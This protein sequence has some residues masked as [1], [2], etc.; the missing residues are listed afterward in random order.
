MRRKRQ[1]SRRKT[2]RQVG[3][4]N[5]NQQNFRSH[6]RQRNRSNKKANNRSRRKQRDKKRRPRINRNRSSRRTKHLQLDKRCRLPRAG[7]HKNRVILQQRML[8]L[9]HRIGSVKQRQTGRWNSCSACGS[10]L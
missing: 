2:K 7:G 10:R 5:S 6:T 8:M 1:R 9:F 3:D 4:S